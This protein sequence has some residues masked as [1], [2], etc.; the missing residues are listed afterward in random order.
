MGELEGASLRLTFPLVAFDR[1][2]LA[3]PKVLTFGKLQIYL[4][5]H[6]LNRTFAHEIV[7]CNG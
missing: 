3:L 4:H 5:F 2:T 7:M 1:V 6:L